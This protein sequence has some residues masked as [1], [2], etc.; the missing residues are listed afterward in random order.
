M[1]AVDGVD[2][3][4]DVATQRARIIDELN[5]LVAALDRRVPD[6]GR[7]GEVRIARAAAALR[8]EALKRIEEL[9]RDA[10]GQA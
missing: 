4:P 7:V 5:E 2:T 10:E 6:V 1:T 8:S 9:Q 3:A